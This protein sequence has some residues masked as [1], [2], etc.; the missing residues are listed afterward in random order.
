MLKN[1]NLEKFINCIEQGK[2]YVDFDAR[3][4]HNHGTKFRIDYKDVPLVY[5]SV[6][7][8]IY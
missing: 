7:K 4:G 1:V 5:D 6:T 2:I 8:I 3:T